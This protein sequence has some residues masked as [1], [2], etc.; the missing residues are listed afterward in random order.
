MSSQ[1]LSCPPLAP[2]LSARLNEHSF[3]PCLHAR[4]LLISQVVARPPRTPFRFAVKRGPTKVIRLE[5]P[6]RPA[7]SPCKSVLPSYL[8]QSDR[9]SPHLAAHQLICSDGAFDAVH[10]PELKL[11]STSLEGEICQPNSIFNDLHS[12]SLGLSESAYMKV[13]SLLMISRGAKVPT[14]RCHAVMIGIAAKNPYCTFAIPRLMNSLRSSRDSPVVPVLTHDA[15]AGSQKSTLLQYF[16]SRVPEFV[17]R[18]QPIIDTPKLPSFPPQ[19]RIDQPNAPVK[20]YGVSYVELRSP[21]SSDVFASFLFNSLYVSVHIGAEGGTGRDEDEILE[22]ESYFNSTFM[23]PTLQVMMANLKRSYAMLET[24]PLPEFNRFPIY[25]LRA[26]AMIYEKSNKKVLQEMRNHYEITSKAV[27]QAIHGAI[28]RLEIEMPK[29]T[30][31]MDC[32][33]NLR[34]SRTSYKYDAQGAKLAIERLRGENEAVLEIG[35]EESDVL[36]F[37]KAFC[38]EIGQHTIQAFDLFFELI[39]NPKIEI[40]VPRAFASA[41]FVVPA[42]V[43]LFR[44]LDS[45]FERSMTDSL[46]L[47]L[48]DRFIL[49]ESEKMI[50]MDDSPSDRFVHSD[51]PLSMRMFLDYAAAVRLHKTEVSPEKL[52]FATFVGLELMKELDTFTA[53]LNAIAIGGDFIALCDVYFEKVQWPEIDY[54]R[55]AATIVQGREI[56]GLSMQP[57][58]SYV[59]RKVQSHWAYNLSPSFAFFMD[60]ALPIQDLTGRD[61][62]ESVDEGSGA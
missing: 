34:S 19:E 50:G 8:Q 42:L 60:S 12:L 28:R 1:T 29:W 59:V 11:T 56:W 10:F 33:N 3:E 18:R 17:E 43:S 4:P 54:L 2:S 62:S 24:R 6:S 49:K 39:E 21:L 38:E 51:A 14:R 22:S 25:L 7:L 15:L 55:E 45:Q 48:R 58:G 26:I 5:R 46:A 35:R 27:S 53:L 13:C 47:R 16:S 20:H 57:D 52:V 30:L 61:E 31:Y 37:L 32:R 41:L 9:A 40:L 44:D 23:V 36:C